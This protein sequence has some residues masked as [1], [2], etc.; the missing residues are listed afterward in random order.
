MVSIKIAQQ[1]RNKRRAG[2]RA[3]SGITPYLPLRIGLTLCLMPRTR[4]EQAWAPYLAVLQVGRGLGPLDHGADDF[5]HNSPIGV[6]MEAHLGLSPARTSYR[7]Q[8]LIKPPEDLPLWP[9]SLRFGGL[10]FYWTP[11][12]KLFES[13]TLR[14]GRPSG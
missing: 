11:P 12:R 2:R 3:V 1:N 4:G 8:V 10:T 5:R 13:E 9:A 7:R 6:R 14:G